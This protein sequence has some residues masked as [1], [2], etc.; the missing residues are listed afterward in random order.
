E[1]RSTFMSASRISRRRRSATLRSVAVKGF[2]RSSESRFPPIASKD[3]S[4]GQ[5]QRSSGE[6][7]QKVPVAVDEL[8]VREDLAARAKVAD[9]IPVQGRAVQAPRL[10]IR[11]SEGEVDRPADLLVEQ[12]VAREELH[13][14]VQAECELAHPPGPFVHRY[15]LAEE[16]LAARGG[17]LDHLSALEAK[18]DAVDLPRV[19]A[20]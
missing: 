9:Q 17:R 8:A 15:H 18:P 4:A 20:C 6:T 19:E 1:P 11:G 12:G 5:N 10:R 3:A 16:V 7:V 13:R 14:V 2:F